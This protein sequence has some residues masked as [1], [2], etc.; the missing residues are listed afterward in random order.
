MEISK[1]AIG[2]FDSG[3]GGLT[4]VSALRERL[5]GESI[6]YL[7]DTARLPYGSK[8][9]ATVIGYALRS[10]RFLASHEIKLLIVACNTASAYALGALQGELDVPVLGVVQ[11]GARVAA[12]RTAT[13]VVGVLATLGTVASGAYRRAVFAERADVVVHSQA[14][15]LFVPLAEEG[16]STHPVT[17]AVAAHYLLPLA[18]RSRQLD[19]LV[20]GCTHY[21]LLRKT[22]AEQAKTLF[23]RELFLVDSAAAVATAAEQ[24]LSSLDLQRQ[25]PGQP[26]IRCFVTDACR[27]D[28]LAPRFLGHAVGPPEQVELG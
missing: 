10:A 5:A 22:I 7:G 25:G 23:G 4:V 19:T 1:A 8:S 26:H 11:P 12:Q 2:V 17:A 16:W 18:Q 21:P 27:F 28:E 3:L 24:T 20:L 15:P 9:A 6:I 14:C 13:G